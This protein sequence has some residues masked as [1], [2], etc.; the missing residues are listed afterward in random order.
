[1]YCY[2]WSYFVRPEFVQEFQT[3]YGPEGDWGRFFRRD[4]AYIR[5][6]LLADRD[7][8]TRFMTIDYWWSYEAWA[9]FRQRFGSEFETLDKKFERLTWEEK[10][11]GSF[12]LLDQ[13][14]PPGA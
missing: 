2:V 14:R 11:I 6:S 7:N 12:N 10:H 1:M 9:S 13:D 3:A 5:T 8:P 4:S